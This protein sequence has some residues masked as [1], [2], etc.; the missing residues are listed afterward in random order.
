MILLGPAAG[1]A[2]GAPKNSLQTL[3]ENRYFC[4][5]TMQ[6]LQ[7][8]APMQCILNVFQGKIT[9]KYTGSVGIYLD[10]LT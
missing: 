1:S 4:L 5:I 6:W 8:N 3:T 10:L 7:S 9:T 2:D